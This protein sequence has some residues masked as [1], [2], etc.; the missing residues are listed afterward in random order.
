MR[1]HIRR[2]KPQHNPIFGNGRIHQ[3]V[4]DAIFSFIPLYPNFAV[5]DV[6]NLF[7][8]I[9]LPYNLRLLCQ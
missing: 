9:G 7:F 4:G 8:L 5:D 3:L 6:E 2:V 1:S